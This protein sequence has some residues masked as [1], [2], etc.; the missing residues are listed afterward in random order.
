M[1]PEGD[2]GQQGEKEV[3]HLERNGDL[4]KDSKKKGK[5]RA[6]VGVFMGLI[7]WKLRFNSYFCENFK[8]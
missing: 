4:H 7:G 3:S 2:E 5:S 6:S 8:K 1:F